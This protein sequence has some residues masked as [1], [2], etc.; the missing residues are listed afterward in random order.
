MR[1]I[2]FSATIDKFN[3]KQKHVT[4][5][6]GWQGLKPDEILMG[7]EKGQGL[8]RGEKV[9]KLAPIIILEVS[10][11]QVLDIIRYP[12]RKIPDYITNRYVG[13]FA[14]KNTP[15]ETTLE[16][17]PELTTIDFVK[18]FCEMNECESTTVI[19]RIL[20]DYKECEQ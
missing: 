5:R 1:N 8:K 9:K 3:Q 13:Y 11:E 14:G 20:F 16:G 12:I 17:F 7:I 6:L 10:R 18:M 2:S 15:P 4:R 19:T